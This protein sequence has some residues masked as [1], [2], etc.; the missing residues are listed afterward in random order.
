[1]RSYL[2]VANQ[3]LDSPELADAISQRIGKG[4]ATFHLV[5]PV[6]P[7]SRG[8]TWDED[9]ARAAATER[10]TEAIDRFRA[11][12]ATVSGEI[13]ATDPVQAAQDALRGRDVDEVILSTLPPG[14]SRWLGQDVPTRLTGSVQGPVAVVT[15]QHQR[16]SA[17]QR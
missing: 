17:S 10:L 4:P 3:T 16:E 12:G 7:I 15:T 13:G 11:A 2:V 14:L 9:E 1:M 8:F 5:V 6:T